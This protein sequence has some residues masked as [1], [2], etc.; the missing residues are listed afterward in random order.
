MEKEIKM[1]EEELR[2]INKFED[3]LVDAEFIT[4]SESCGGMWTLIC[5]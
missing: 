3:A 2:E 5:C 1:L 4:L